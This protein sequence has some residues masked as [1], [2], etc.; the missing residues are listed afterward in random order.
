MGHVLDFG[1]HDRRIRHDSGFHRN[2]QIYETAWHEYL[3]G[4]MP[5]QGWLHAIRCQDREGYCQGY[6]LRGLAADR[7]YS[8]RLSQLLFQSDI[9]P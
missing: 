6:S 2:Q 8:D 9:G 7:E 3:P 4:W 5:P 1:Q